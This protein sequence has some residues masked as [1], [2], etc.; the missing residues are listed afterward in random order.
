MMKIIFYKSI[1]VN[2]QQNISGASVRFPS[3]GGELDDRRSIWRSHQGSQEDTANIAR[4]TCRHKQT[5]PQFYFT[6]RVWAQ[7]TVIGHYLST[8]KG[9]QYSCIKNYVAC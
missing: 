5:R 6:H 8:F 3:I 7:T 9:V 1:V 2:S 4:E